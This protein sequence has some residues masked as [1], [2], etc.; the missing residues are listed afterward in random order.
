MTKFILKTVLFLFLFLALNMCYL[1]IL[2]N[3]DWN[4]SKRMEALNLKNPNYD[5]LV[6]GNSLAMDG[7]DTGYMSENNLPS[8]NLAVGGSSIATC[9]IQLKEYL[10]TYTHKPKYVLVGQVSYIPFLESDK[11]IQ[12]IIDFTSQGKIYGFSD[13]PMLKFKWLLIDNL[14]K[15]ISEPHRNAYLK[16]GQLRFKKK[17]TDNTSLNSSNELDLSKF[18]ENEV[19]TEFIDLCAS[20][21]IQLYFIEMPGFKGY[22][23]AQVFR[24][25]TLDEAE[26]NS[27]L[28]DYNT[29]EFG[30]IFSDSDDWIGGSHLNEYGARKFTKELIQDIFVS[31][32]CATKTKSPNKN[33]ISAYLPE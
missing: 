27:F 28:I 29:F 17:V 14:K 10:T 31:D 13:L 22:R 19:L 26:N 21:N 12:P 1:W 33:R 8:Y 20:H 3:V 23:H 6:L 18:M 5:V 9:L 4:F 7:I 32:L 24:C 30:R 2:Q 11:E 25:K 16:N 15:I